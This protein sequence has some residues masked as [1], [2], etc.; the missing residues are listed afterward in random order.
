MIRIKNIDMA[1]D[2]KKSAIDCAKQAI[3]K[4]EIE[5][6]IADFIRDEFDRIYNPTWHCIVG[7]QFASYVSHDT[8]HFIFFYIGQ[9]GILLFRSG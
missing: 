2:M 6:D 4:Y 9:I 3:D 1:P 5:K 8:K 7:R